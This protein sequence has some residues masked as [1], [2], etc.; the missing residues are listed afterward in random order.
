M[1]FLF[2]FGP[3]CAFPYDGIKFRAEE[4]LSVVEDELHHHGLD[5]HLHERCCATKAGRLDLSGSETQLQNSTT[6]F[7]ALDHWDMPQFSVTETQEGEFNSLHEATHLVWE[8]KSHLRRLGAQTI[9]RFFVCM[10][11]MELN[12]ARWER[13]LMRYS[14]VL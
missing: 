9:A 13:C 8:F 12:V 2:Q 14:R 10:L 1:S 5:T 11:V 7:T 3:T 6:Y 4:S